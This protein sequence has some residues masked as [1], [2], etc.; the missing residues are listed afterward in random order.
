VKPGFL[1]NSELLLKKLQN[2]P[3]NTL[4]QRDFRETTK[5]SPKKF[6][7][8]II[9]ANLRNITNMAR[10]LKPRAI[11]AAYKALNKA[12]NDEREEKRLYRRALAQAKAQKAKEILAIVET[13]SDDAIKAILGPSK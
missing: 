11:K 7:N 10:S 1:A 6:N 9:F 12:N 2:T 13:N 5:P 8:S 3:K 4:I